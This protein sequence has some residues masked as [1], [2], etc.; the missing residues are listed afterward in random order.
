MLPFTL[1]TH[2]IKVCNIIIVIIHS[3][4][5]GRSRT[6]I[7]ACSCHWLGLLGV[8][9]FAL[10]TSIHLLCSLCLYPKSCF[11]RILYDRICVVDPSICCSSQIFVICFRCSSPDPGA[12]FCPTCISFHIKNLLIIGWEVRRRVHKLARRY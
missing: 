2:L 9:S 8:G 12:K 5:F 11:F 1:K 3:Q 6:A 4:L 10:K 7:N